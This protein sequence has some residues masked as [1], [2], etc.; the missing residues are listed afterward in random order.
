MKKI[1]VFS[2][3]FCVGCTLKDPQEIFDKPYQIMFDKKEILADGVS[4]I[5]VRVSLKPNISGT[6][7]IKLQTDFGT[8][9]STINFSITPAVQT[10]S[11]P[12]TNKQAQFVLKANTSLTDSAKI[13]IG[14]G[15]SRYK[16]SFVVKPALAEDMAL[17][18]KKY[19]MPKSDSVTVNIKLWRSVGKVTDN[20][21]IN[22]E[23]ISKSDTSAKVNILPYVLTNNEASTFIIKSKNGIKGD[24]LI[25]ASIIGTNN[26]LISKEFTLKIE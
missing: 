7:L 11:I 22:L 13:I 23:S 17:I 20:L 25:K 14:V 8:I 4:K 12:A 16:E 9:D 19:S 26:G 24:V 15:T 3:L 10:L 6:N 18:L 1:I 5:V 2:I 21:K